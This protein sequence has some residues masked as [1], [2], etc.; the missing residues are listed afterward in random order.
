MRLRTASLVCGL[1][2]SIEL[3][4]PPMIFLMRLANANIKMSGMKNSEL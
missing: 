2:A 4:G 1:G 3:G